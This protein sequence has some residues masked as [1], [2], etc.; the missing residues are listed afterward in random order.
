MNSHP[1]QWLL[2]FS[3]TASSQE[4]QCLWSNDTPSQTDQTFPSPAL[5]IPVAMGVYILYKLS[6]RGGLKCINNDSG[7]KWNR[8]ERLYGDELDSVY[9]IFPS[10]FSFSF[11]LRFHRYNLLPPSGMILINFHQTSSSHVMTRIH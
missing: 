11:F 9:S 2:W 1:Q 5:V 7:G 10:L 8:R 4:Q 6:T 3:T